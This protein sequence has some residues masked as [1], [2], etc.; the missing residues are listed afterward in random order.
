MADLRRIAMS[1]E[2]ETALQALQNMR[3]DDLYRA[4]SAFKNYTP[5]QMQEEYGQSGKTPTEIL[6]CIPSRQVRGRT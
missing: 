4:G 2:K 5:K 6:A 1:Q 3:G